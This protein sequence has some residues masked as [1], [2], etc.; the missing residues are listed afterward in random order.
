MMVETVGLEANELHGV[1]VEPAHGVLDVGPVVPG[2]AVRR[3]NASNWEDG[4][5]LQVRFFE[6]G[7]TY[8]RDS[9]RYF[10]LY[11]LVISDADR[12]RL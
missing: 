4:V 3:V 9:Y 8:L 12:A 7:E 2:H 11:K 1:A 5:T 6:D 10:P